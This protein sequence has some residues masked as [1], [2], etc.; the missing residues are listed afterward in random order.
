MTYAIAIRF[1]KTIM[2]DIKTKEERSRNMSALRSKD[3]D[4]EMYFRKLLFAQGIRYR[5]NVSFIPGHPDLYLR[6]YN[7]AIFINGCFWHAHEHCKY[8]SFPKSNTA[9]WQKKFN[10]NKERDAENLKFYQDKC[11]RVCVVWECAI[12]GKNSRQKIESV[13]DQIIQWLEEPGEPFLEI[14][15]NHK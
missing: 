4:P 12:R 8:F 5:K 3:T 15:E 14:K 10:R 13:K 6:K 2:A 7:T 1:G 9:F 11:W